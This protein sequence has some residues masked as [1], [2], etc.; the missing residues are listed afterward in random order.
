MNSPLIQLRGFKSSDA[1]G[2]TELC[3]NKKIA[4]NLRDVFPHPYS[5]EDAMFFINLCKAENPQL[6]FAIEFNGSLCG[7]IGLV[8]QTDI[9]RL[10]AEVGY[11]IGEPFWGKGIATKALKKI[12]RYG[13][14]DL[15]LIRI[16]AGV[17]AHNH[18]SYRVLEKA[19]FEYEGTSKKA[20]VK[21]EI[22]LDELRFSII[23]VPKNNSQV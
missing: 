2:L 17:F 11:W 8:R 23:N 15:K 18:A 10:S 19:G 22:L 21:N 14:E 4:D 12:V 1:A 20:A 16:Y 3:N 7:A 13:F 6:T 5:Q 9:Y